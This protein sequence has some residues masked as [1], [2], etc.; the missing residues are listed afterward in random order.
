MGLSSLGG[1]L[2]GH[3]TKCCLQIIWLIRAEQ[4]VRHLLGYLNFS[5]CVHLHCKN[6]NQVSIL[7]IIYKQIEIVSDPEFDYNLL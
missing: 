3:K 6:R 7:Y 2:S 4:I 5:A 1:L